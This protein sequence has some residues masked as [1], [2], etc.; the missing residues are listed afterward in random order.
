MSDNPFA[1]PAMD[2]SAEIPP[3]NWKATLLKGFLFGAVIFVLIA[4][5]IPATRDARGAA[6]RTQCKNNLKQIGLA[7]YNYHD[8]YGSFPPAY[9]VDSNGRMLHS[10][11]TLL[12]PYLDHD[13]FY[14][15]ID[16]SK[17]WYDPVN[18]TAFNA[19]VDVFQCRS[20]EMPTNHTIYL[21]VSGPNCC[22]R[23]DK[24]TTFTDIEDGMSYTLM[25]VEVPQ[26]RTV[27]WM[28]PQDA[29]EA[30]ILGIDKDSKVSHTGGIQAAM[31]DG[32]VRFISSNINR[33]TLRALLTTSGSE[34]VDEF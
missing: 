6:R 1:I 11:R 9:T 15:Q 27:P 31:A 20:T 4:L 13:Q 17:P 8:E 7:L 33:V 24:P 19:A 21:G 29:D 23:D 16:F 34:V 26:N 5:L 10:W 22:F 32:S 12:L 25:V 28:S 2:D 18:A 14:R 30:L 3:R